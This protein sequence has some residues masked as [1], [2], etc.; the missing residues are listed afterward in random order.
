MRLAQDDKWR[1]VQIFRL[2]AVRLAQ[3]DMYREVRCLGVAEM[4]GVRGRDEG[5]TWTV[6]TD[7]LSRR[8]RS[9]SV[10]PGHRTQQGRRSAVIHDHIHIVASLEWRQSCLGTPLFVSRK[11]AHLVVAGTSAKIL[12][13]PF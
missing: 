8:Q 3:D 5:A 1:S 6:V 11:N 7:S 4:Q 9:R 13:I 12:F 10:A 2:A